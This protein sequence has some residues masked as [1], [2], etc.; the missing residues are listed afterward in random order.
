MSK[1]VILAGRDT[2][3]SILFNALKDEFNIE[4]I[5]IENPVPKIQF[6]KNRIKRL[7]FLTVLGQILFMMIIVPILEISSTRRKNDII[8]QYDLDVSA[9]D[10]S[11]IIQVDSINDNTTMNELTRINP[12]VVV[13][14]GTRIISRKILNCV[15]AKFVNIHAG[16]TPQYRGVHGGYWALVDDNRDGC[17]V[18]IHLVDPGIDTGE[19]LQQGCISTSQKDNYITYP[20]IQLGTGVPLLKNSLT[21]LLRG[22]VNLKSE[23][24]SESKLWSHPTFWQYIWNR[25][26][27]GVK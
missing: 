7:G 3:T 24:E 11:K 18:T 10:L 27:K 4:C 9:I 14:N 19:I 25:L 22:E 17:G 6:L 2:S 8:N 20:L 15:D 5:I 23:T 26:A 21:E 1:I 12:S 16:I 13:I